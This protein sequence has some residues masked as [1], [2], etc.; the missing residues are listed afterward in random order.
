MNDHRTT[1]D[2]ADLHFVPYP[3]I[4]HLAVIGDSRTAAMVAADGMV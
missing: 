3:S 2:Q 1:E 4:E